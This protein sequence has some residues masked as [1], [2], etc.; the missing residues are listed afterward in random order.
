M[1]E[2][3]APHP[4]AKCRSVKNENIET[5]AIGKGV[6]LFTLLSYILLYMVQMTSSIGDKIQG[7]V[8]RVVTR[9]QGRAE[10]TVQTYHEMGWEDMSAI[11]EE[12]PDLKIIRAWMK[13]DSRPQAEELHNKSPECR[14]YW[15]HWEQLLLLNNVLYLENLR[16]HIDTAKY[17][18]IVPKSRRDEVLRMMHSDVLSGHLGKKKTVHRILHKYYWFNAKRDVDVYIQS[19]E[20]CIVNK[21]PVHKPRAPLGVYTVGAPMDRLCTDYLGPL[22]ET[23]RS[24]KFILLITDSFSKYVELIPVSDCT[25]KTTADNVYNFMCRHGTSLEIH[26]DQGRCYE[27]ELFIHLCDALGV[28][29]TRN[30]SFNPKANG[31]AER[32]NRSLWAMLRNY[33]SGRQ[34]EW[35]LY[36]PPLAAAYNSSVH[37][38]TAFTPNLLFLG[39]EVRSPVELIYGASSQR[40]HGSYGEYIQ[41][42]LQQ[43]EKAY[44][45]ARIHLQSAVKTNKQNYDAKQFLRK[46]CVG[47]KVYLLN[48]T[49]KPGVCPK[50]TPAYSGPYKVLRK[51]ND[52]NYEIQHLT[53]T[54]VKIVHHDKLVAA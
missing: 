29:K 51:L 36:L 18:L 44:A 13:A 52:L 21:L 48:Q 42:M 35:D 38:S 50:L 17:Q 25:A 24:N 10:P 15:N 8:R 47:Q 46:Y 41:K 6:R 43:S 16:P 22:P 3:M 1:A 37:S 27:S 7:A 5:K 28:R 14:H 34:D 23:P 33:I 9:S 4:M 54:K 11:Q 12:D 40:S 30:S 32:F 20:S 53:T 19:C 49:R 26:S 45:Q 31:Q 2:E 39:R